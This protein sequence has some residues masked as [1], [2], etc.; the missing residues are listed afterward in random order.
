MGDNTT[1]NKSSP[2]TVVGGITT[3]SQL[4]SGG[5]HSVGLTSAGIAYAWGYGY[6]GQLGNNSNTSR[7]SPVTVVGGINTWTQLSAGAR[8]SGG[9]AHTLGLTSAGIAYAWGYNNSGQ[10]GDNTQYTVKSSPVTVVGGITNWS[11]L[12]AGGIHSLGRTSAGVVYAW[13]N[14]EYGMSGLNSTTSRSSPVTIV[15]GITS[16]SQI[17]AGA[18]G[19]VAVRTI[20]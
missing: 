20:T 6:Q 5:N 19:S 10:L 17:D 9:T 8:L 18:F 15:G 2:V 11:E 7:S 1:A 14:G 3:W 16:W 12:S 4:S 13:G